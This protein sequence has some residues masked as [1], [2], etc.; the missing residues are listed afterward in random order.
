MSLKTLQT[1]I[2]TQ[3]AGSLVFLAVSVRV[4]DVTRPDIPVQI[5]SVQAP[6]TADATMQVSP[7]DPHVVFVTDG[8]SSTNRLFAVSVLEPRSPRVI[9]RITIV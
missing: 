7:I 4:W 8:S 5:G 1:R 3:Y 9:S 6:L 2:L